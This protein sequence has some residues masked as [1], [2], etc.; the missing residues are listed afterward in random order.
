MVVKRILVLVVIM[1]FRY[2]GLSVAATTPAPK[3]SA[4]P[5]AANFGSV[6]T[7][8]TSAPK[9]ITIRNTGTSDLTI[10]DV[11]LTGADADEFD[12]TNGCGTVAPGGSCQVNVTITPDPPYAK[13]SSVL[14]IASN[15]PKKPVLKVKLSG[16]VIPP[17][18]SA[19]PKS[20]NFGKLPAG[21]GSATKTVTVKNTGLSGL[22]INSVGISGVNPGDFNAA[23]HCNVIPNGGSCTI[24]LEFAPTMAAV[25]RSGTLDISSNDPQKTKLSLKLMGQ[26]PPALPKPQ[27]TADISKF[28]EGVVVDNTGTLNCGTTCSK[29]YDEGAVVTFTATPAQGWQL[30]HWT[31]CDTA[32]GTTCT[33]TMTADRTIFPTFNSTVTTLKSNVVVL[34]DATMALLIDQ[35]GTTLIF[36][37]SATAIAALKP[38][39]III[40]LAGN[41]LARKVKFVTTLAGASIF[42]ETENASL[43]DIL[44]DGTV[45]MNQRLSPSSLIKAVPLLSGA[46]LIKEE[47]VHAASFTIALDSTV[48][49]LNIL[50]ST[51]L[52]IEPDFAVSASITKGINEFK[53][54]MRITEDTNLTLSTSDS[55]PFVDT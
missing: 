5:A 30:H 11:S 46:K 49:S 34:D 13:K 32:L 1:L 39:D 4:S 12:Q 53:S 20:V 44:Q 22:V 31:G 42:V 52:T 17:K 36:D 35:A 14:A 45:I 54:V 10:N 50:G 29:Q 48:G 55:L 19:T 23:S 21:T 9:T 18:I 6:K 26:A 8:A 33:V 40:S 25:K 43:Q 47:G 27:K 7:G 24:D 37:I 16:T 15:D 41:G 2:G 3:I 51:T 28:G 38:G